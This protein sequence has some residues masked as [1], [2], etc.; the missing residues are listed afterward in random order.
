ME[1]S[2]T[3]GVYCNKILAMES[4]RP[5]KCNWLQLQEN[6][7]HLQ[8]AQWFVLASPGKTGKAGE[9]VTPFHL[10]RKKN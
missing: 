3:Q 2:V 8:T 10:M 4:I 5:G 1:A 6:H 7:L 9:Q